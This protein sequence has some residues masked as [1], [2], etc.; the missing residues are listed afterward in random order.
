[1]GRLLAKLKR[2]PRN[3]VVAGFVAFASVATGLALYSSASAG[4]VAISFNPDCGTNAVMYCGAKDVNQVK[5]KYANGDGL[6]SAASLHHIYNYSFFGISTTDINNMD[7]YAVSGYVTRDGNVHANGQV[8]ATN[9]YT[10]GRHYLSGSTKH[11]VS[12]TTFYTRP[13]SISFVTQSSFKAYVV[14]KDG[15]FDYAIL[16]RC[17]NPV[18]A[19]PKL[20][21]YTIQKDV[22]V[23]GTN[24]WHQSV[25]VKAGA[26]VEYRVTV[27][28]TGAVTVNNVSVSDTLPANVEYVAN[29]LQRNGVSI[30]S[31]GF[32]GSGNS[33]SRIAPGNSVTYTFDAVVAP[34][35]TV[36]E[37]QEA[38]YN[39]VAKM[40]SPGLPNKQDDAD[41]SKT[42]APKPALSCVDLVATP[43][44]TPREY[45]FTTRATAENGATVT[46]YHYEF[47]VG[48]NQ[49]QD[50]TSSDLTNTVT[51]A[52]DNDGSYTIV[53]TVKF[54]V[55]GE[56]KS[57]TCQTSVGIETPAYSCDAFDVE[58][59]DNRTV[60]VNRFSTSQSG[61]A[62][63]ANVVIDWGDGASSEP[64]N[65]AVG[66]THQYT[67]D[68]TYNIV[69]TAYFNVPGEDNPV[70]APAGH[71][72]ASVS[73]NT[74]T[75]PPVTPPTPELPNTGAG[76]VI[77]FFSATTIAGG[78]LHRFFL[79]RKF[80]A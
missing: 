46:G 27:K 65:K 75:P 2:L 59:G 74:P 62:E 67:A 13:T 5:S 58:K 23:K 8:V 56:A 6:N 68:G 15:K 34:N 7:K 47:G 33:V 16:A 44:T 12:G 10:A 61:G 73:F 72:A 43:T 78:L 40:T 24:T 70:A 1:M 22:R 64:A 55:L 35:E 57:E 26:K 80:V 52:Y 4:N 38:T 14:M 3:A 9:A 49:T 69:A 76:D 30:S 31:T 29:S 48:D 39:N 21:N 18:H 53:V 77:G 79:R 45:S 36:Y 63:Y 25:S 50:E 37:C 19:K 17:G 11:V 60:T 54:D 42:C 66:Q 28:S 51:H 32:F 41:V 71:C 20:P